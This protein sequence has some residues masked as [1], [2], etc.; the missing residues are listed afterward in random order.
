MANTLRQKKKGFKD[1][2]AFKAIYCLVAWRGLDL[3][4]QF[5]SVGTSVGINRK[6]GN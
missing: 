2:I 3:I 5:G 4:P 1:I 6:R